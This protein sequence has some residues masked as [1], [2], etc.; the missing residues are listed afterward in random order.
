MLAEKDDWVPR[1]AAPFISLCLPLSTPATSAEV[2]NSQSIEQQTGERDQESKPV[3][4]KKSDFANPS[5]REGPRRPP[6][7]SGMN[8]SLSDGSALLYDYSMPLLHE[9]GEQD[10]NIQRGNAE[11]QS[12]SKYVSYREH[13]NNSEDGEVKPKK[14]G[15]RA[16]MLDLGKEWVRNLKRRNVI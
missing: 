4:E 2:S 12:F 11:S 7:S 6:R 8:R 10:C 14:M 15:R 13:R 1:S 9:E 3:E 16:K 5:I